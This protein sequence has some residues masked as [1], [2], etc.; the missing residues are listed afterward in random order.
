MRA[1]V[2]GVCG[3]IVVTAGLKA[4]VPDLDLAD[5][6][7]KAVRGSDRAH[8]EQLLQNGA[9]VNLRDRRG[10]A[11]P[12]MYA[13]ALGS[14]DTMTLLIDKGADVN[15]RSTGGATALMWAATDLAKIRL[16]LDRGADVN[17]VSERGRTVLLLAAMSDR[18]A[19]IVRLLLSRRADAHTIDKEGTSTLLAATFG[20][21]TA[22]I[23]QLVEAGA[24]V[25]AANVFGTPLMNAAS[26]GN[27]G[28]VKLLLGRGA[29]VN[30]VSAPP[31][32][33]V[34]NGT[35]ALGA[36]TPLI[37]ASAFGPSNV[38]K[39]LVDAGA[40][41]NAKEARGM[42]PLMYSA[43]TDHGDIAIAR[44]LIARGADPRV[45][46]PEGETALDWAQK[47][48]A[49]PIVALLQRGGAKAAP[50]PSHEIPEP[51]PTTPRSALERSVRLL[52][53]AS[54][55]FFV[56]SACGACHAQNVTDFAVT[57]ARKAGVTIDDAAA[58]RRSSGAAATFGSTAPRLFERFDGPALD[59]LL[60][61]LGAFAAAGHPADRATDA[62]L[63]N[64]SAQQQRDGRWHSGGVP[65][66]P[67]EDGDFSRTALAVRALA[68]YG[69]PGRQAEM[70]ERLQRAVAWLRSSTPLTAEDRG[71]RLLGLSWGGSDASTRQRAARDIMALQR[72]DGGWSQ[73]EEMAS[74]AYAT[75]LTLYALTESGSLPGSSP[76][77]QR[78]TQYL[79]S[80]QRADGSWFV[81][82]RSPKFQ[83]YFEGGFP[84]GHDQWISSM[85]TGWATAALATGMKD[86]NSITV[87]R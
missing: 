41:V 50:M 29:N 5:Q 72:P 13:A 65:R 22:T 6:F 39:A 85:A 43:T 60:F 15:A 48:G 44:M 49:T 8:V 59:I 17:A 46:T 34:K 24:N 81:R 57:A 83:P 11:T 68:V 33:Q 56:N 31:G 12:L 4:Q 30:A 25:N 7:Y 38:V 3:A 19:E 54:G 32:Q 67:I 27:Y 62:L 16:L 2:V 52:E 58:A 75:G 1:L 37:L 61:T 82:S 84:Y 23:R 55:T 28:A 76:A 45:K 53:R 69:L 74:D 79:L 40:D 10:G 14:L 36:F 47:S 77:V 26:Q 64:V 78:G 71:F 51:A 66:P 35:I 20:N 87:L 73:R 18:S 70:N 21:D 80:T 9:D 42:T 86:G 63:F